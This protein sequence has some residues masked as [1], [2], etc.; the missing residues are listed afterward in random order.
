MAER[1]TPSPRSVEQLFAP[2]CPDRPSSDG[3]E[4]FLVVAVVVLVLLLAARIWKGKF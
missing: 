1:C 4:S 2:S 3:A